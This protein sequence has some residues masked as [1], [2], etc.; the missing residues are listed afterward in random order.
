MHTK[1]VAMT[2]IDDR[3]VPAKEPRTLKWWQWMLM[4]PTLAENSNGNQI[5]MTKR[6]AAKVTGRRAYDLARVPKR[7]H[8]RPARREGENARF[9]G[10]SR[11][12]ITWIGMRL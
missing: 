3:P 1:R 10:Y 7:L 4:Y 9:N 2:Q 12:H 6:R 8:V 5:T 11:I